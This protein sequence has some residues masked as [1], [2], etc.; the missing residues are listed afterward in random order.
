MK[1]MSKQQ[2]ADCADVSV[3]TLMGWCKRYHA[4]LERMGLQPK[5]R[6]LPPNVVRFIAERYCIDV[7]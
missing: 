5:A 6:V 3:K 1:A 7:E 2:L 4:E